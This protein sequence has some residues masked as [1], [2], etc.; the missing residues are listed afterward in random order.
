MWLY[1]V[2]SK[3]LTYIADFSAETINTIKTIVEAPETINEI[4]LIGKVTEYLAKYKAE[5]VANFADRG[6]DIDLI[7]NFELFGI[8]LAETPNFAFL[9]TI[10]GW[11]ILIP[12][13]AAVSSWLS[14]FLMKKWNH[15]PAAAGADAQAQASGKMMDLV[16]PAMSLFISFGLSGMLGVYWIYQ[17]VFS[18]LQSF[19][20]SKVMPMPTF[21][22]EDYKAAERE[23]ASKTKKKKST[24]SGE[25]RAVRS[26][27]YINDE[28]F[29]DTRERGLARRA[30]IEEK[31]KQEQ[32]EK[33]ERNAKTPF[34]KATL[35]KDDRA[36]EAA[37][38]APAEDDS[39]EQTVEDDNNKE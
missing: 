15:N 21:S 9:G 18:I 36:E 30:A 32:E 3:P 38:D 2:I 17:S 27:H 13:L 29:E 22:E 12:I 6:I 7:P 23:M 4:G 19:I 31:E 16:M 11:L 5:G 1:G 8:N 14:M 25:V 39:T 33:A 20:I 28:D 26:L 10:N 34:G 37:T 35:K 24:K